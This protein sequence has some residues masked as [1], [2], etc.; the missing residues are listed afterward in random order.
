MNPPQAASRRRWPLAIGGVA[1]AAGAGA[2]VLQLSGAADVAP[3]AGIPTRDQVA[4]WA[5]G[6]IRVLVDVLAVT[7]VGLLLAAAFLTPGRA[8]DGGRLVSPHGYRWLRAAAVTATLWSL[9]ALITLPITLADVLATGVGEAM[10]LGAIT[11]FATTVDVGRAWLGVALIAALCAVVARSAI[12]TSGAAI[13]LVLA[14]G[15]ILPVLLVGHNSSAGEHQQAVNTQILH[16]TGAALWAGGLL[17][18]LLARKLS[19]EVLAVAAAR[20]SRLAIIGFVLVAAS[21]L[22]NT[23]IRLTTPTQMLTD[24]YGRIML[25]KTA[26]LAALAY[27]GWRHRRRTLPVLQA[28]DRCPFTRLAIIEFVLFAAVIGISAALTRTPP[29]PGD[30]PT[31][32]FVKSLLGFDMPPPLTLGTALGRWYVDPLWAALALTAACLYLAAVR[33]L[34]RD[35]EPWPVRRAAAWLAG[36]A[37]AAAATSSSLALYGPVLF[38]GH[39]AQHLALA[40]LAPL[41]LALGDPVGLARKALRPTS[42]PGLRGPREWLDVWAT[43]APAR[44]FRHPTAAGLLYTLVLFGMYTP[45]L[46]DLQMRSHGFH[47]A[48]TALFLTVGFGF[49]RAVLGTGPGTRTIRVTVLGLLAIGYAAFGAWLVLGDARLAPD[50]FEDLGRT[51]GPDLAA[52]H[53]IGGVLAWCLGGLSVLTATAVMW[54]RR[55]VR[56]RIDTKLL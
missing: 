1:A 33:R 36:C 55:M 43:S 52:D 15:A 16:V 19:T 34:V 3:V 21:G 20:Y 17:A 53:R 54:T 42:T 38:S 32:S 27:I 28:G 18:L 25:V 9:A 8:D 29:A 7:T 51:W 41:G 22:F 12:T 49:F 23:L 13:A 35:G 4:V 39:V 5:V 46:L 26:A 6:L 50:W 11:S 47:L 37:V 44:T 24:T 48:A 2:L 31:E 10:R 56:V 14:F 30:V 45:A 40:A